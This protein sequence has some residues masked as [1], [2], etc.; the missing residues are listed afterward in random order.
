MSRGSTPVKNKKS[1]ARRDRM[2]KA[3]NLRLTGASY[4]QIAQDL[5]I[6]V[7][8]AHRDV[9][10]ALKDITKDTAAEVLDLELQRYDELLAAHYPAALGGNKFATQQVLSI[11]ARI[12]RLNGVGTTTDA[13]GTQRTVSLLE[14]I[15]AGAAALAATAATTAEEE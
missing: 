14:T 8:T 2:A 5:D 15:A 3:L 10:D 11:L 12:E 1:K 7:V 6:S 4:R 9:A 13:V